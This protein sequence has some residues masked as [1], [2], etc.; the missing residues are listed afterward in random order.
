MMD[1]IGDEERRQPTFD[2]A[3]RA[4]RMTGAGPGIR[5]LVDESSSG[6]GPRRGDAAAYEESPRM[7]ATRA[8]AT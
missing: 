3:L 2:N 6:T 1:Q 8:P 5:A 7:P 4:L